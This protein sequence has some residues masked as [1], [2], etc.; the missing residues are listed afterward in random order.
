MTDLDDTDRRILELLAADARRPYSDIAEDV[1]LSA[2]AVSDRVAKLR[3]SGVVT[4]FTVDIDRSQLRGGAQVLVELSAAPGATDDV[5][6][7][8]A[9]ADAVEHVFVTASGNVVCSARL[10][11]EDVR[12]WVTDTVDTG[13]VTDYEVTLVSESTWRPNVGDEFA[14]ACDEC[15]NTVTSEGETARIDGDRYHFCCGSCEARF[16]ERYERLESEA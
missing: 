5:R 11:V 4:R 15:G 13:D 16:E 12:A 8:V 7:A 9:D 1:G 6:D 10:P 14:H 2:P 3:E